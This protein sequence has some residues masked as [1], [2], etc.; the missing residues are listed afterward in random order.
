[1]F[2]KLRVYEDNPNTLMYMQNQAIK[3]NVFSYLNSDVDL[4]GMDCRTETH[5]RE[6]QA[7]RTYASLPERAGDLRQQV[8]GQLQ[9]FFKL[10]L[11]MKHTKTKNYFCILHV[12][13]NN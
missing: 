5:L 10:F 2:C 3:K 7:R 6:K 9:N 4:A 12:S 13:P 8:R 11:L 1:M